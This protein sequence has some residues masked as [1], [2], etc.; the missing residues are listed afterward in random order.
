MSKEF[1]SVTLVF[2]NSEEINI[3]SEDILKMEYSELLKITHKGYWGNDDYTTTNCDEFNIVFK[4]K[5]EYSRVFEWD[6]IAQIHIFIENNVVT[7]LG[8]I[9][10]FPKWGDDEN[11]NELQHTEVNGEYVTISI[12]EN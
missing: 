2:E 7:Q 11:E 6:G 8:D 12:K 5:D 1:K 9:W 3:P 10:F 4:N